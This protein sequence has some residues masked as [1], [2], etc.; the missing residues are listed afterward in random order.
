MGKID[1]DE[2]VGSLRNEAKTFEQRP[3]WKVPVG[4]SIIEMDCT[5]YREYEGSDITGEGTVEK[6]I[7][8]ILVEGKPMAWFVTKGKTK[9]SLWGQLG[10]AWKEIGKVRG[11][12]L[13]VFRV[14]SGKRTVYTVAPAE[15]VPE[16][17][18]E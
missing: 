16:R 9:G 4:E 7:F 14:G 8:D 11:A 5:E 18:E 3:I 15:P 12:K 17:I 6:G 2:W 1:L 10:L 13:K